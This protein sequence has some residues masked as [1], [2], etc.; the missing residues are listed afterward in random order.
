M[1][2]KLIL[3]LIALVWHGY[4]I[5]QTHRLQKVEI[6]SEA[7]IKEITKYIDADEKKNNTQPNSRDGYLSLFIYGKENR[8]TNYHLEFSYYPLKDILK[9]KW[10]PIAYTSVKNRLVI[11]YNEGYTSTIGFQLSKRDK[12]RLSKEIE[13]TLP[14]A[15]KLRFYNEKGKL[16]AKGEKFREIRYLIHGGICISIDRDDNIAEVHIH[17]HMKGCFFDQNSSTDK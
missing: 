14:R 2:Q 10:E 12:R 6:D 1:P 11:I 7:L 4:L 9:I 8:T 17:S 13:K 3:L 15:K 5:G 16:R